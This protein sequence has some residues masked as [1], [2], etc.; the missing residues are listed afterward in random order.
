[1]KDFV[2][3][4]TISWQASSGGRQQQQ[5]H[6]SSTTAAHTGLNFSLSRYGR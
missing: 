6:N 5:Q 4:K 3:V 1:M 2:N